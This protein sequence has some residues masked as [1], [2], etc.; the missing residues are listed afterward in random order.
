MTDE[1]VALFDI[2]VPSAVDG[3]TCTTRVNVALLTPSKLAEQEIG[4][5]TP[6]AGTIQLQ[7]PATASETNVVSGG[8]VSERET[9]AAL[10]GPALLTV[11]V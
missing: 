3:T 7:P 4:P 1:V 6:T 9:D 2:I 5:A 11:I 8:T 10:T